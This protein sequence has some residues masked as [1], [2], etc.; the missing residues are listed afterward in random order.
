LTIIVVLGRK[1]PFSNSNDWSIQ[2]YRRFFMQ[3][4][5]HCYSHCLT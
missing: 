2:H 5:L 3:H 4:E 1:R